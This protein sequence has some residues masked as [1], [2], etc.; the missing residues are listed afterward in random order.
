VDTE[1]FPCSISTIAQP[2]ETMCALG[3]EFLE[4]RMNTP[5]APAQQ[6]LLSAQLLV[7]ESS[8]RA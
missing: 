3:W 6:T 7:R 2:V 8:R 4:K 1:Y 5:S